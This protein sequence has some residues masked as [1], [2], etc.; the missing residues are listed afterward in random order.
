MASKHFVDQYLTKV[1]M[2]SGCTPKELEHVSSLCT[3]LPVKAGRVL[4]QEGQPGHEFMIIVEGEAEVTIGG[5]HVV[6]L[7]QGGFFGETSLLD[8][9]PRTAT[10][11]AKTD[12]VLEV[13]GHREFHELLESTP[14]LAYRM[15]VANAPRLR[16]ASASHT[17]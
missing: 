17:H 14:S 6:D 9:G 16:E 2:F 13:I 10:V 7:A 8:R 15:L 12:M 3:P 5:K 11:T 1:P 4:A